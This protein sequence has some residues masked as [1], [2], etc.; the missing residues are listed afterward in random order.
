MVG[1]ID[2][3]LLSLPAQVNTC[4]SSFALRSNHEVSAGGYHFSQAV[5][6]KANYYAGVLERGWKEDEYGSKDDNKTKQ[7]CVMLIHLPKLSA[8]MINQ[9]RYCNGQRKYFFLET[10]LLEA[11]N[12]CCLPSL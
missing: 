3:D 10:I 5:V 9:H 8:R 2:V 1:K 12:C 6:G 11:H 7:S 4:C